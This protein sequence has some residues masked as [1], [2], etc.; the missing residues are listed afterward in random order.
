MNELNKKK[1]V[2][3]I[4]LARKSNKGFTPLD[5]KYQTGFTIVELLVSI[6]IIVLLS[7]IFLA[8]M[9]YGNQQGELNMAAQKLASDIRLTQSYALGLKKFESNRPDGGWGIYFTKIN[10]NADH[11]IIYADKN[12]DHVFDSDE[13]WQ[14]IKISKGI[15]IIDIKKDGSNANKL[16]LTF[17]P[18][19]PKIWICSNTNPNQCKPKAEITLSDDSGNFTKII[20]VNIFGLVDVKN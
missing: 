19:N 9:H 13:E 11:Y 16:Y 7:G 15:K 8:N 12:T 5:K 2:G 17:E 14:D 3:F 10:P 6:A 4:Q 1:F 20:K 18:P